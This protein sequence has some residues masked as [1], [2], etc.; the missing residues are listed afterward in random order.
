MAV[1]RIIPPTTRPSIAIA[2]RLAAL[3][4]VSGI[5]E[6]MA[7][8]GSSMDAIDAAFWSAD[9]TT[10]LYRSRRGDPTRT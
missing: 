3:L 8:I 10:S 9:R 5:S 1:R 6:M 7:S 4:P 2:K